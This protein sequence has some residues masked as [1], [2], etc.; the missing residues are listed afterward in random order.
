V[1]IE[2]A[3]ALLCLLFLLVAIPV[4]VYQYRRKALLWERLEASMDIEGSAMVVLEQF[5]QSKLDHQKW[6]DSFV[7]RG[8]Q[9]ISQAI[10]LH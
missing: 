7:R 8:E 2:A 10:R 6:V 5:E 9:S 1:T 4:I 3:L